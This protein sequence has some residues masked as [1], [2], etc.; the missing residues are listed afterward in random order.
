LPTVD[1][2]GKVVGFTL[3]ARTIKGT[4]KA[5]DGTGYITFQTSGKKFER[6]NWYDARRFFVNKDDATME[7]VEALE[8]KRTEAEMTLATM[9]EVISFV[10][11]TR[12]TIVDLAD[13]EEDVKV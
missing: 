11:N 1:P 7:I 3:Y 13:S 6:L 8:A 4:K 12:P 10:E 9:N 2:E 5:A